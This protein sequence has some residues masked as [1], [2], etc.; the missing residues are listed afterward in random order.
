MRVEVV[1]GGGVWK[2]VPGDIALHEL[3][4][5]EAQRMMREKEV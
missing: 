2:E 1:G 4:L 3:G 5:S